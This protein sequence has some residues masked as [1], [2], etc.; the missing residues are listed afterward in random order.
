MKHV[1]FTQAGKLR[2]GAV[3]EEGSAEDAA[4]DSA[5]EAG[6]V[7]DDAEEGDEQEEWRKKR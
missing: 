3:E 6:V 2:G 4:M 1:R 5:A 7:S